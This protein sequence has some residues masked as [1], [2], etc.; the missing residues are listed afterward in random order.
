MCSSD[1]CLFGAD[2]VAGPVLG[3]QDHAGKQAR[4]G[5]PS[6]KVRSGEVS[7]TH[8]PLTHLHH[9]RY[10]SLKPLRHLSTLLCSPTSGQALTILQQDHAGPL[11]QCI[12]PQ[13]FSD[14]AW[15]HTACL[16]ALLTIG[17][18]VSTWLIQ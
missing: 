2:S 12:C 15:V 5:Q 7:F 11:N 17:N 13:S 18:D 10:H 6:G 8:S 1:K 3:S 4:P 14:P 9:I 16:W